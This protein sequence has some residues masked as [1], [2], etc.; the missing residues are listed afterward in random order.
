MRVSAVINHSAVL[1]TPSDKLSSAM[2]VS[3]GPGHAV[4]P[5]PPVGHASAGANVAPRP[6]RLQ[7][8]TFAN[9]AQDPWTRAEV[10]STI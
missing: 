7:R 8:V 10:L 5:L 6:E 1:P 4:E 2:H 3:H 9:R